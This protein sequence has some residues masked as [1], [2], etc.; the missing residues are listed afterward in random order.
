MTKIQFYS[1]AYVAKDKEPNKREIECYPIEVLPNVEGELTQEE[2]IQGS[3][4]D[5]IG[6]EISISLK[7]YKTVLAA[8]LP[9]GQPNRATA[10]DVCRGETVILLRYGTEDKFYW[11]PL[12]AEFD[13]RK[14][15]SVLY[16]FSN[17]EQL[18]EEGNLNKEGYYFLIDTKNKKIKLHTSNNDEEEVEY[19]ITID[20]KEGNIEILD[21]NENRIFLNSKDSELNI[22][23][24][25][26][27]TTETKNKTETIEEEITEEMKTKNITAKEN[28]LVEF[29]GI[30]LSNGSDE[31]ITLLV[32]L[33]DA[34][35]EEKHIGNMGAPTQLDPGSIMKYT[36]IK[37]KLDKFKP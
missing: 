24:I 4:K 11:S 25:E 35:I 19:N 34:M 27:I 6:N 26:K 18:A 32:D 16:F 15:E 31:L 1:V 13:L 8:W 30:K 36:M 9:L 20:T 23:T 29:K 5:S 7:K 12:G 37:Q 21:T 17:K 3:I 2:D 28:I 22:K 33:I 10:P 14:K